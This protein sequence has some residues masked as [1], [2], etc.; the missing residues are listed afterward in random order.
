[1]IV[2]SQIL[3]LLMVDFA[4]CILYVMMFRPPDQ[5]AQE[6]NRPWPNIVDD[7]CYK[8]IGA[9]DDRKMLSTEVSFKM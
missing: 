9:G 8:A 4:V 1:M 2:F 5:A 7:P 3:Y 6:Q